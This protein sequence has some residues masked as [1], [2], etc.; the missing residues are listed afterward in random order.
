MRPYTIAAASELNVTQMRLKVMQR[1][2]LQQAYLDAWNATAT[3][4]PTT[5]A[6]V[7]SAVAA[8]PPMDALILAVSPWAAP[9]LGATQ[10]QFYVGY[11]GVVNFLDFCAC[12]FPVTFADAKK[13][14]AVDMTEFATRAL[15]ELDTQIQGEYE[16]DVYDGA[17]V[18]LQL[19]GRRLEEEKVLE[20]VEVVDGVLKRASVK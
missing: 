18:S 5:S 2:E 1:N 9:R 13:D 10:K 4:P 8:K 15:S 7:T 11:T 14:P 3:A 17:P 19:V 12:T 20:M 6:S 16:A